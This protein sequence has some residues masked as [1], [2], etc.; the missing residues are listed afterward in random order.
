MICICSQQ[1]SSMASLLASLEAP[2]IGIPAPLGE[3]SAS[4]S[5]AMS[6][7][8]AASGAASVGLSAAAMAQVSA[9]AQAAAAVKAGLGIDLTAPGAQMELDATIAGLNAN[10]GAF[11]PL[12]G[13]DPAP[14]L[15]L[16]MLASLAMKISL[17]FGVNVF[18][19]GAAAALSAALEAGASADASLFASAD[20]SASLSAMASASG[21]ADLS[22]AGGMS[23]FA[24]KLELIAD[25]TTPPIAVSLALLGG[26]PAI[27]GAMANIA[28]GLG[29][30][31]LAPGFG[32]SALSLG[33]S[34]SA[35]A[36]LSVP[37]SLAASLEASAQAQAAAAADASASLDASMLADFQ[38]PDLGPLTAMASFV[39]SSGS[40]G[41]SIGMP[42]PCG[43]GCPMAVAP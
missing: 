9:A 21:V 29:L 35:F 19:A 16:S 37:A 41:F 4:L 27:L 39:A 34:L 3:L 17:G 14:W 32:D 28:I 6:A 36:S 8:A 13:L 23:A 24:A 26:P 42:S 25:L 12:A 10:A 5:A 7:Q 11:Q 30:N 22:L 43:G 2:T 18:A 38:A 31:P 40:L 20:A 1:V 15:S 33:S